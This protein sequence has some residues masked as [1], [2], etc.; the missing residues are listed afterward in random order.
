MDRRN[1]LQM[2]G[3]SGVVGGVTITSGNEQLLSFSIPNSPINQDS[4]LSCCVVSGAEMR[5][6]NTTKEELKRVMGEELAYA[7]TRILERIAKC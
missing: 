2:L 6:L 1:F 5:K 7:R 4:I 3:L